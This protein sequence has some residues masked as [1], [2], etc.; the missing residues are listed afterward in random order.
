MIFP[1][2]F[3]S[4]RST[5]SFFFLKSVLL[6]GWVWRFG[7][8]RKSSGCRTCR[9]H[10]AEITTI[11]ATPL[12]WKM[13]ENRKISA[14]NQMQIERLRVVRCWKFSIFLLPCLAFCCAPPPAIYPVSGCRKNK[15]ELIFCPHGL[16]RR[17]WGFST[18]PNVNVCAFNYFPAAEVLFP[19]ITRAFSDVEIMTHSL[20]HAQIHTQM[21]CVQITQT[22]FCC[23]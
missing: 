7:V 1:G 15:L 18:P 11:A 8:F 14:L 2:N 19:I 22:L 13:S 23:G 21:R 12:P 16:F 3:T 9:T 10:R 4:L 5:L 6:S 20:A 17:G